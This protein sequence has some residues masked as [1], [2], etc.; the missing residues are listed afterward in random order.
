MTVEAILKT[1][2][3]D[4]VTIPPFAK[5][6]M[7]ASIM[8]KRTIGALVV[9]E[10]GAIVG[11]ISEREIVHAFANY[12]EEAVGMEVADQMTRGFASCTRHDSLK[13]VMKVM[14]D[15]RMR[16]CPVIEDGKLAGMVSV[17]DVVK[18]RLDELEMETNVLRDAFLA[19]Q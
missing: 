6:K 16:H 18:H 19:R 14:T 9:V 1:K 17:G 13:S 12:G 10:H 2:G 7:A 11:V 8:R 5:L 4:V 3:R 15:R